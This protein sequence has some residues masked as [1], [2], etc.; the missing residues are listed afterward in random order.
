[1]SQKGLGTNRI[2]RE[3]RRELKRVL[4]RPLQECLEESLEENSGGGFTEIL[5]ESFVFVFA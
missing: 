3:H 5:R 4:K 2:K 1:M